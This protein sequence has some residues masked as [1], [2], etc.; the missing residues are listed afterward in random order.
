MKRDPHI[1]L[2]EDNNLEA[3]YYYSLLTDA[4]HE[5]LRFTLVSSISESL[6]EFKKRHS[7][8]ILDLHGRNIDS[9]KTIRNHDET[10]PILV[11]TGKK[12]P[13]KAHEAILAGAND[14]I[15]RGIDDATSTEKH[16]KYW[17]NFYN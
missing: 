10:T 15:I 16:I 8:I 4:F 6:A 11:I 5:K 12:N 9:I 7:L 2:V 1:L 14:Y 13:D 3:D 17:V